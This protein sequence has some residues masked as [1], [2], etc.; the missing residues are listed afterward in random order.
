MNVLRLALHPK[1]LA[2]RTVN[3]AEWRAHLLERLRRLVE[4]TGTIRVVEGTGSTAPAG[5]SSAA[6]T[7]F[8]S[9]LT[10]PSSSSPSSGGGTGCGSRGGPGTRGSDGRCQSWRE[11]W[12][13]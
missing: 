7:P 3:L 9:L 11:F 1:G 2:G 12:G 8:P 10:G 4:L 13:R 5:R 6:Q